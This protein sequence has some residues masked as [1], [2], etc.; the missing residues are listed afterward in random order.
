MGGKDDRTSV[1]EE[2]AA[3]TA[4]R[5]ESGRDVRRGEFVTCYQAAYPRLVGQV[6]AITG[7]VTVAHEVVQEGFARA[8]RRWGSVRRQDDPVGWVRR[9]ALRLA[10]RRG[11]RSR[12][13]QQPGVSDPAAAGSAARSAMDP[14]NLL[15]L[16]ALRRIPEPER[17]AL[18]LHHMAALPVA[19]IADEE[20]VTEDTVDTRLSRGRAALAD[21]LADD[22]EAELF[23]E[24]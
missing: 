19:R 24:S 13:G 18:V 4:K 21:L 23:E 6:Q 9:V 11:R 15:V 14:Q 22:G 17:R 2:A 8:W 1:S 7:D 12:G 10:G 20:G 5:N 16:D 3:G